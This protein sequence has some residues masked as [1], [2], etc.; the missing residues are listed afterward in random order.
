MGHDRPKLGEF[1]EYVVRIILPKFIE[2]S[3]WK[4]SKLTAAKYLGAYTIVAGQG[5]LT[6]LRFRHAPLAV[7]QLICEPGRESDLA[8][9]LKR[10]AS[11]LRTGFAGSNAGFLDI[12]MLKERTRLLGK[13]GRPNLI[14]DP[15]A[16]E[17]LLAKQTV[18]PDQAYGSLVSCFG[19]FL[20][21]GLFEAKWVRSAYLELIPGGERFNADTYQVE[22]LVRNWLE[23][24]KPELLA[25]L[26]PVAGHRG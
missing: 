16:L 14:D 3:F 7:V 24:L 23:E 25:E 19:I 26:F 12:S 2:N 10:R 1:G 18:N 20:G 9:V 21:L 13:L 22:K 5:T 8:G 17:D 11:D 15:V 4:R 6:G